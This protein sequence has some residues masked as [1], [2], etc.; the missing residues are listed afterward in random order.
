MFYDHHGVACIHEAL[1]YPQLLVNL[2]RPMNGLGDLYQIDRAA[3]G[4]GR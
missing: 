3:L 1:E 2:R 4:I